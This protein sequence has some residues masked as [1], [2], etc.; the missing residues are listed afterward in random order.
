MVLLAPRPDDFLLSLWFVPVTATSSAS[1]DYL[2]QSD[3]ING[4][5]LIR[6][7]LWLLPL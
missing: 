1:R 5:Y 3:V 4:E 7:F 2:L 6:L